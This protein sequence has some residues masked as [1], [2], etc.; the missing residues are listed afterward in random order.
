MRVDHPLNGHCQPYRA[1]VDP[2]APPVA[3]GTV[4][5]ERRPAAPDRVEEGRLADDVEERVLLAGEARVREV[6]GGGRRPDGD[7]RVVAEGAVR[8][9]HGLGDLRRHRRRDQRRPDGAG[10]RLQAGVV[11]G[12]DGL[13]R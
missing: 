13:E 2:V 3:H 8:H 5:P 1:L 4:G 6:F 11:V 12:A 10:Q 9:E 7:R